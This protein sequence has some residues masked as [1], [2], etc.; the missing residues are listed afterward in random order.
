MAN[1]VTGTTEEEVSDFASKLFGAIL[2]TVN[3]ILPPGIIAFGLLGNL[4]AFFVL[5]QPQ[6]AQQTTCFYMRMLSLFDNSCL[7]T[8]VLLRT[9]IN[10]H[11]DAMFWRTAGPIMCPAITIAFSSYGLSNWTIAAM[12]LDRFLAVRFPLKA[13]SLCTLR[14]CRITT[15]SIFIFCACISVPFGFRG[16]N[17]SAIVLKDVCQFNP[18]IFPPNFQSKFLQ[19]HK[20]CIFSAPFVI[21]LVL[22][23]LIII[24]L[25]LRHSKTIRATKDASRKD[26]HVTV[27]LLLVT[28]VFLVTNIPVTVDTWIWGHVLSNLNMTPRISIIRKVAYECLTFVL[29]FSPAVNFYTYCLGCKKFRHDV[30]LMIRKCLRIGH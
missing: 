30:L 7:L 12:T 11:G 1:V 19:A 20:F 14:R 25:K 9:I 26:G 21:V 10:Y 8:H 28:A 2:L 15:I 3:L 13:A 5:R 22:N 24:S 16:V 6:Y 17:P 27:L 23:V 29:F 4:L 18:D